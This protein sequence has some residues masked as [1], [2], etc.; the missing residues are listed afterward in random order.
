MSCVPEGRSDRWED[1]SLRS[2][3]A[4]WHVRL[5]SPNVTESDFLAFESWLAGPGA[6]KAFDQIE[7]LS[8]DVA[9]HREYLDRAMTRAD[10]VRL[11]QE[12]MLLKRRDSRRGFFVRAAGAGALAAAIVGGVVLPPRMGWALFTTTKGEKRTVTLSDGTIIQLN[13]ASTLKAKISD[14]V[15]QV[16]MGQGEAAFDVAHDP[17]RRFLVAVGAHQVRVIGTEF[18]ILNTVQRTE[19]T[20]R[21]G[22]VEVHGAKPGAFEVARLTP[23]DQVAF[24]DGR[25]VRRTNAAERAFAWQSGNLIYEDAT[26]AD[27]V[28]DLNRYFPGPVRVEGAEAA[29][30]KFSG[31][32][33]LD[34]KEQVVRRLEAFLPIEAVSVDGALIL[35]KRANAAA[36]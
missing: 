20:V 24:D 36:P 32:L 2:Q 19:I 25:V 29:S 23:G 8:G 21:R 3:A 12:V 13:S 27:L 9:A 16:V 6:R 22:V 11:D 33:A 10:E 17:H 35:R 4:A 34:D 14:G 5:D 28:S 30:L 18:N 15:R 1:D 26:L 7:T 31:V